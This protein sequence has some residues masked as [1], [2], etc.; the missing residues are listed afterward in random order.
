MK[1]ISVKGGLNAMVDDEDYPVL[2]RHSWYQGNNGSLYTTATACNRI[3]MQKMVLGTMLSLSIL[4]IDRNNLNNQKE[5][6]RFIR[7][8][9]GSVGRKKSSKKKYSSIYKG[10]YS[11]VRNGKISWRAGIRSDNKKINLGTFKTERDAAIAYNRAAE[12]YHGD[13]ALLNILE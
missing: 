5:N 2:N 8:K 9:Q 1:K 3:T 10:V 6:L 13:L 11:V 12:K 7:I 4:H